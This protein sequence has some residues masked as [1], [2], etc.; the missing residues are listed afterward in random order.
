MS[1][2]FE[3][4]KY[5]FKCLCLAAFMGLIITSLVFAD[6][7]DITDDFLPAAI[8]VWWCVTP[9]GNQGGVVWADVDE[10]GTYDTQVVFTTETGV[11]SVMPEISGS[12]KWYFFSPFVTLTNC[13]DSTQTM[14]ERGRFTIHF[15][16]I[17]APGFVW[18]DS[19]TWIYKRIPSLSL[20]ATHDLSIRDGITFDDA[21]QAVQAYR[22]RFQTDNIA[23]I[24]TPLAGGW[25]EYEFSDATGI[26][27]LYISTDFGE[28][29]LDEFI[30]R[31]AAAPAQPGVVLLFD[32]SGSMSWDHNGMHGVPAE[33]QRLSLA[34]Q[35]A[36]PFMDLLYAHAEDE[37]SFGIAEFPPHPWSN[38]VGCNGQPVTGM[39]PITITSHDE[40]VTA[41]IPSLTASGN[42]P[43][44]AGVETA[45]GM[46]GSETAKTIV[47]LSDGYHNCPTPVEVGDSAFTALVNEL[48]TNNIRVYTI[49]FARPGD[50]DNHFLDELAVA[51][52]GHWSDVTQDPGFDPTMWHPAT[53]L[54][55]TYNKILADGLGLSVTADPLEVIT[56]GDTHSHDVAINEHD[57]KVSFFL[58]WVTQGTDRLGLTLKSSDDLPVT[59]SAA[60]GVQTH[61]GGTY[62]I[63]TVDRTFLQQPGKIGITPWR[64]E[65]S[66]GQVNPGEQEHYQ[67]SVITDSNL[68]MTATLD[69]AA[70]ETGDTMLLSARLAEPGRPLLGLENV[71]VTVTRPE[72]GAGNWYAANRVTA[73]ELA[74]IG[75]TVGN[76]TLHGIQRK[77]IFLMDHR[78]VQYPGRKEPVML[79]LY[80]DG[81]HGD[82]LAGDGVYSKRF[83]DTFKEGTYSFYF[84][85]KGT[86]GGGNH[87]DRENLIQ[88]YITVNVSPEDITVKVAPVDTADDLVQ[89]KV[90]V[91]PKD[92]VGNYLGPRYASQIK[93]ATSKGEFIGK[94]RDEL[95][96]A[97]SQILQ[98]PATASA[99]DIDIT[100]DVRDKERFFNLGEMLTPWHMSLHI[101][102]AVPRGNFNNTYDAGISLALDIERRLSP[103]LFAQG[104]IGF[105][106]F[107][108][109]SPAVSDTHWWNVS[110][111][112]KYE[113]TSTNPWRPYINGGVGLYIPESGASKGGYNLGLGFDYNASPEWTLELGI[114][115]HEI[116]TSGSNTQFLVPRVGAI[117]KF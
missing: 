30:L 3:A 94:V 13:P 5:S 69:Q 117:F 41:T 44:L 62:K 2:I 80:D 25:I 102:A 4:K 115:H 107:D 52:S 66:T 54:A 101:G 64:I 67:Y 60:Q 23:G 79:N 27:E 57:Q 15:V 53:A 74:T 29:T 104:L 110:A 113:L 12:G 8:N 56:A 40:A 26:M 85:A 97:Y 39:T 36:I 90:I 65:V 82:Q 45:K 1:A 9:A 61:Q 76:E 35:A 32:T 46:F 17:L 14:A 50:V 111:N 105:N 99:A 58:S 87:F 92:T 78:K 19:T 34:K 49:G 47:L 22:N 88:K 59:G 20:R 48:T 63:I 31:Q 100:L 18:N 103:Q 51:T 42:T 106:G 21:Y 108:A 91:T 72:D 10:D 112:L 6:T 84:Q 95:D 38:A 89:Y 116:F 109:G 75:T 70:Y 7:G 114:D 98:L 37:A 68:K 96:G 43:L 86:T 83:S 71:T 55:S 93:L 33:Q 28:N 24:S 73:K 16:D 11:A 77:A 81:S